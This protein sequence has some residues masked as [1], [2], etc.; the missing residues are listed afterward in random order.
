MEF[1]YDNVEIDFIGCFLDGQYTKMQLQNLLNM[2]PKLKDEESFN[3]LKALRTKDTL[4]KIFGD[5]FVVLSESTRFLKLWAKSEL[6][7]EFFIYIKIQNNLVKT[8]FSSMKKL[9]SN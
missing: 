6:I 3:V 8:F 4:Q 9:D 7:F 2:S 1:E 5:R